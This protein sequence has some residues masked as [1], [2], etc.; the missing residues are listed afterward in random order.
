MTK[1][2]K[3][4]V[5]LMACILIVS[6][7]NKEEV[8]NP[9]IQ[10]DSLEEINEVAN[11]KIVAPTNFKRTNEMFYIIDNNT[12]AYGFTADGYDYY[13][14]GCQSTNFD[15]SGVFVDGKPL[16]NELTLSLDY[17]EASGY[18][19][20]R[21]I[22]GTYQYIFGVKDEGAIEY[23]TFSNQFSEVRQQII[24]NSAPEE[25]KNLVGFYQDSTSQR[26]TA[27]IVLDDIDRISINITW[28][29]SATD[30]DEWMIKAKVKDNKANYEEI[31]HTKNSANN[32]DPENLND[33][34]SGYFEI[35]EG[36]LMWTGSGNQQTDKCIFEIIK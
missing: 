26:A 32:I 7:S 27:Q 30:Y 20:F 25:I 21:F 3:T 8:T 34:S 16:F 1:I 10:Y 36:K 15:M 9:V 13:I 28:S 29:S 22:V 4:V 18:K 6:C 11:T 14:R 17:K 33:Y 2:I 23:E 24:M 19:V 31:T 12:A 5:V 35:Q